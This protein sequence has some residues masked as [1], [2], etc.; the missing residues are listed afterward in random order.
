MEDFSASDEG[1]PNTPVL[2]TGSS[3]E[4]RPR[5]QKFVSAGKV[6]VKSWR[7]LLP[8]ALVQPVRCTELVVGRH[9]DLDLEECRGPFGDSP[10]DVY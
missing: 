5:R 8:L 9:P 10:S 7:C 1:A 6:A 3:E 4:L 2:H